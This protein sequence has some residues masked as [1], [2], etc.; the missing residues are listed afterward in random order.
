MKKWLLVTTDVL[1][2]FNLEEEDPF[3][4]LIDSTQLKTGDIVLIYKASPHRK[5]EYI[6]KICDN[7]FGKIS[8]R[9]EDRVHLKNQITFQEL[10]AKNAFNKWVKRLKNGI[11]AIPDDNW[12]I[13]KQLILE[14]NRS[15]SHEIKKV[16]NDVDEEN[17]HLDEVKN[18]Y[19]KGIKLFGSGYYQD[20]LKC[21]DNVIKLDPNCTYVHYHRGKI[22]ES[23]GSFFSAISCYDDVL[24]IDSTCS[25]ALHRKGICLRIMGNIDESS[26]CFDEIL[27]KDPSDILFY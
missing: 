8:L 6:Y 13:I 27:D 24:N 9:K 15:Q 19:R 5:I 20:A 2:W 23:I 11:T 12:N 18:N 22:F 3:T 1:D 4:K 16:L 17:F 14:R 7:Q 10:S 25:N 21:F 26:D